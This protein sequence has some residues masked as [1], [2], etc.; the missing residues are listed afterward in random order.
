[1]GKAKGK[2]VTMEG[3]LLR[4]KSTRTGRASKRLEESM[5][6]AVEVPFV[7]EGLQ[8]GEVV[9]DEGGSHSWQ[10]EMETKI[11]Q[12]VSAAIPVAMASVVPAIVSQV[13]DQ[14]SSL[15]ILL[16]IWYWR[17]GLKIWYWRIGLCWV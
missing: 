1:M 12:A 17:I 9:M 14:L 16:K 13:A 11:K 4:P 5:D 3:S 6:D 7:L 8:S 10:V 2:S 15:V